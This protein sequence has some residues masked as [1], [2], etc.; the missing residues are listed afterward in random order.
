VTT[1]D[2]D[3][4]R[5]QASA[6]MPS[7]LPLKRGRVAQH[8]STIMKGDHLAENVPSAATIMAIRLTRA[9]RPTTQDAESRRRRLPRPHRISAPIKSPWSAE[10]GATRPRRVAA[11]TL[12]SGDALTTYT[13]AKVLRSSS[14]DSKLRVSAECC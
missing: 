7:I 8:A 4:A 14:A 10:H 6:V 3:Q 1:C 5:M 12:V 2:A 13:N 11:T 9:A